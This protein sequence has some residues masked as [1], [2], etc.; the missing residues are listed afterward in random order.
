V[1]NRPDKHLPRGVF[2]KVQRR[3]RFP[4]VLVASRISNDGA[5]YLGPV[6]SRTFADDAAALVAKSFALRTCSM[7]LHPSEA[8]EPCW[9]GPAGWCSSPCNAAATPNDYRAQI[10]HAEKALNG[11]PLQ[12]RASAAPLQGGDED[13]RSRDGAVIGRLL[14]LP[15]KRHWLVN[16]H[17][18]VAAFPAT[19]GGLWV[20]TVLGGVCR[21]LSRTLTRHELDAVLTFDARMSGQARMAHFE[22][23]ASTIL[24][25]WIRRPGEEHGIK[26]LDLDEKD[27]EASLAA[28]AG[29]LALELPW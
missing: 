19:G 7:T 12:L 8:V 11:D 14:K 15:R 22:A 3:G 16:T 20:A 25:H 28:A 10:E 9:L 26:I 24:A 13:V 6:K 23:D 17:A 2:V 27:L 4:R 5:L 29:K 1:L 21:K 18:Y